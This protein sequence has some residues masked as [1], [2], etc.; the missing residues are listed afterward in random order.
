MRNL[1][2]KILKKVVDNA[3][4]NLMKPTNMATGAHPIPLHPAPPRSL[5]LALAWHCIWLHA[6]CV[7]CA[8][9]VTT[10]VVFGPNILRPEDDLVDDVMMQDIGAVN[11]IIS[12][13]ICHCDELLSKVCLS[14]DFA[15]SLH[16]L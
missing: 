8:Q 9:C 7:M 10:R 12:T 14:A 16:R 1:D 15:S 13:L 6:D 4:H 3:E 11:S 5:A 2:K